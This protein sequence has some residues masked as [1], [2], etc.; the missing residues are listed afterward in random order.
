MYTQTETVGP[1][2]QTRAHYDWADATLT[3][4]SEV[5]GRGTFTAPVVRWE[6]DQSAG[7]P[8]R[9]WGF[10]SGSAGDLWRAK[11]AGNRQVTISGLPSVQVRGSYGPLAE[12]PDNPPDPGTVDAA[13]Q[14]YVYGDGAYD[15]VGEVRAGFS[16]GDSANLPGATVHEDLTVRT[17]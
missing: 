15:A 2:C 11:I 14:I 10:L 12:S 5:P 4:D 17:R 3:P 7:Q 9:S 13:A 8:L 1:G 6:V 16:V